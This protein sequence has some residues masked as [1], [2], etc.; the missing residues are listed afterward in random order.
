MSADEVVL[1]N[2]SHII[3]EVLKKDGSSLE[4][5]TPFAGILKI[6]W[7]NIQMHEN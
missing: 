6:K 1:K 5:K 3:G 2:G 4:F 7:K